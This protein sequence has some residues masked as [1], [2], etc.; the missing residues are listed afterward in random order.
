MFAQTADIVLTLNLTDTNRFW[1]TMVCSFMGCS[2]IFPVLQGAGNG[3][4]GTELL[5]PSL[6]LLIFAANAK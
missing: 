1:V 3:A 2:F 4:L 6:Y 5:G